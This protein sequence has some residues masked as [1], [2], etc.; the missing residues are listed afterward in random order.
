MK[1]DFEKLIQ[2]SGEPKLT[3]A[4]LARELV[5]GGYFKSEVSAL[6]L[7]QYHKKGKAISCDLQLLIFLCK[8]FKKDTN[9]I[10]QW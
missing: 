10:L 1:I 9:E 8:R 4:Q 3:K 6:N 7:M 5:A 2:E